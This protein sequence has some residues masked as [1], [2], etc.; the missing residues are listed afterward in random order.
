MP[1]DPLPGLCGACR[2]SRLIGTRSGSRFRLCERSRTDPAF[3][4]Y[5][6]LPVVRCAGF[7]PEAGDL[8]PPDGRA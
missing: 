5:P 1:T 6:P 4:R 8:A 3:R 2:H 7:E